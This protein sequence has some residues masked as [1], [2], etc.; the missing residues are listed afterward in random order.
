M[1]PASLARFRSA[2]APAI[3][4]GIVGFVKRCKEAVRVDEVVLT[5]ATRQLFV[6]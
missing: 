5:S 6:R 3:P 4:R 1:L 2:A